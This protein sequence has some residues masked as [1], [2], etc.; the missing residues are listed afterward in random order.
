MPALTGGFPLERPTKDH[1]R[2]YARHGRARSAD[3][4]LGLQVQPPDHH[5]Q[6]L[7]AR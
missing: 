5:E 3:L 4:L 6:R 7:L 1:L 2:C